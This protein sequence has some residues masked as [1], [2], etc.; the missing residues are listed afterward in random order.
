MQ[1]QLEGYR[2]GSVTY[3]V[4]GS[5]WTTRAEQRVAADSANHRGLAAGKEFYRRLIRPDSRRLA[6]PAVYGCPDEGKP[7]GESPQIQ[8]I[9]AVL[10]LQARAGPSAPYSPDSRRLAVPAVQ[11]CPASRGRLRSL[12]PNKCRVGNEAAAFP[13]PIDP[14]LQGNVKR[15]LRAYPR[16]GRVPAIHQPYLVKVFSA[17]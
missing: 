16:K 13:V 3:S 17:N 2:H 6:V 14:R 1:V 7:N 8:R 12:A 5:D 11:G 10:E 4:P 15:V 9:T